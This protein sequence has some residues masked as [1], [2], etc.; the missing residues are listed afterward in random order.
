MYG[1][2]VVV[3]PEGVWY[4]IG[5]E[6]DVTEIMERHIV[7]GEIVERLLIPD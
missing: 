6:K 3:Y 5:S 1:P 4:W 7:K 2:A